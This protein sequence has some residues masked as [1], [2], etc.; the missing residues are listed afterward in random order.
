MGAGYDV[1]CS[2]CKFQKRFLL[3][4]GML[5]PSTYKEVTE[6]IKKGKYG[7]EWK[8]FLINTPGAVFDAEKELYQCSKC[9][10]LVTDYNLSLYVSI[11]GQPPEHGYW[12]NWG[13]FDQKYKFVKSYIHRCPKCNSR[14]RKLNPDASASIPCPKCGAELIIHGGILWD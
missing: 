7:E 5:F 9:N 14:M 3:G 4:S 13:Y 11:D 12:C 6:K 1:T 10:N 8:S 2:K